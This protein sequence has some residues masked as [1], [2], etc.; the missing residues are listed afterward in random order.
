MLNTIDI[1]DVRKKIAVNEIDREFSRDFTDDYD[2]G[3]LVG[4]IHAYSVAGI[5]ND[6]EYM[7][8]I[9]AIYATF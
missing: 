3:R 4:L 5:I 9:N 1:I 2:L 8:L 6:Y 7:F